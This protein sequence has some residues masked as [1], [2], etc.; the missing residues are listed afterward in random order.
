M[1]SIRTLMAWPSRRSIQPSDLCTAASTVAILSTSLLRRGLGYLGVIPAIETGG[2]PQASGLGGLQF[3]PSPDRKLAERQPGQPRPN[4]SQ[5]PQAQDLDRFT[6]LSL[7]ALGEDH[8][9]PDLVPRLRFQVDSAG[10][11]RVPV[12]PE[13]PLPPAAQLVRGGPTLQSH[14]VFLLVLES[15]VGQTVGEL[16][17]V[18]QEH[19]PFTLK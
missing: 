18:G 13:H 14:P 5:H 1:V 11:G 3:T 9:N 15:G 7:A 19:Q 12:R 16:A 6:D 17:I 10:R 2:P 4:E 8:L